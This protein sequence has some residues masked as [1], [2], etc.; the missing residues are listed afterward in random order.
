[1]TSM[2]T[3]H[4]LPMALAGGM[5]GC[6]G[7]H[8]LGVKSGAEVWVLKAEGSGFGHASCD[9]GDYKCESRPG[10]VQGR[11]AAV[12]G[13]EASAGGGFRGRTRRQSFNSSHSG[14]A[15]RTLIGSSTMRR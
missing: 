10:A 15:T 1:M 8:K 13:G 12:S 2:P 9:A 6:G 7:C 5:K 14:T 11:Q 4:N 3:T